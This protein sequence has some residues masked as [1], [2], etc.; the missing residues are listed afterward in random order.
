MTHLWGDLCAVYRILDF[1]SA[2]KKDNVFRDLALA[3]I[4]E[5]ASKIDVERVLEHHRTDRLQR[6]A[7][8]G[9]PTDDGAVDV[10]ADV[11]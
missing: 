2:T 11:S 4:I 8:H 10:V 3:R 6:R 7:R 9:V 5:P 1:E